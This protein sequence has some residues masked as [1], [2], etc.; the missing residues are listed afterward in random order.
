M[1]FDWAG[2]AFGLVSAGTEIAGSVLSANAA[3]EDANAMKAAAEYNAA[4][5]LLEGRNEEARQRHIARRALSSQF[6][7]M[8]GKSGVIAEEGGWLEA[9]SQNAAEYEV[10]ALNA[11]IAGRNTAALERSRGRAASRIGEQRYGAE[12]L[13]GASRLAG[14]GLSLSMSG[15]A[16][17]TTVTTPITT[18][19]PRSSVPSWGRA[20]ASGGPTSRSYGGYA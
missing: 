20:P 16:P 3:I 19:P 14:F 10:N 4:L 2:A 7:Q 18:A 9:I 5:A 6:V 11:S 17:A 13:S 1:A 12:L 8:A 15:G